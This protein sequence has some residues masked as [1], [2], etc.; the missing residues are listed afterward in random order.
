MSRNDPPMRYYDPPEPKPPICPICGEETDTFIADKD[1]FI[2]GCD[3]CIKNIDAWD[4]M[5]EHEE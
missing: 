1:D 2:F 5:A 4:W 3:K